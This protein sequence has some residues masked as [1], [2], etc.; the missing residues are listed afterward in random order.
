M[1]DSSIKRPSD[2][3]PRL[4]SIAAEKCKG[5]FMSGAMPEENGAARSFSSCQIGSGEP[6]TGY[7]ITLPRQ[8]GGHYVIMMWPDDR[9]AASGGNEPDKDI[10]NAAYRVLR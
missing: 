5:K 10:R 2:L 6:L 4:I 3:T 8:S 1:L 7:Y 9:A